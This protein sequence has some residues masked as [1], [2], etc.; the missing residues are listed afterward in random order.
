MLID[1]VPIVQQLVPGLL[2]QGRPSV[3]CVRA[4]HEKYLV[5]DSDPARPA[6]VVEVGDEARLRRIDDIM[7]AL[8]AVCPR[9]V[10]RSLACVAWGP[11]EVVHI[12]EGLSGLPWFRLFDTLTTTAAWQG[13]LYRTVAVMRRLHDAVATVPGWVGSIHLATALSTQARIWRAGGGSPLLDTAIARCVE[14]LQAMPPLRAVAQHGDFSLNNLMVAPD[15]MA[16]ID[17]DE[18]AITCVPLHDAVGLGLSFSMSQDGRC[19]IGVRDCVEHCIGGP[20][21]I[22]G[23]EDDVMRGLLLHHLL[24]RINQSQGYGARLRLRQTLT[25]FAEAVAAAPGNGLAGFDVGVRN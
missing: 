18:F 14:R 5:F 16:V 17:F 8:N 2:R 4:T 7:R 1:V 12:Q 13:L 20:G 21:A 9:E 11:G 3:A 6:C 19:P 25:R 15:G 22:A 23:F 10:P 24:W